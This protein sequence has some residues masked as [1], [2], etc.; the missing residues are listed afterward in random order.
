MKL[1]EIERLKNLIKFELSIVKDGINNICGVDEAG[2]GPLAGPVVA[3]SVVFAKDRL[4]KAEKFIGLN[5]SKKVSEKNRERLYKIII[6]ESEDF[7]LGIVSEK[8]IDEINIHNAVL[9]AMELAVRN[10]KTIP[11]YILIDGIFKLKA[12]F[13]QRTII[14]GDSKC[15]SIAAASIIAKVTR[16]RIMKKYDKEFP[17]YGF[18]VHKGYGTKKHISA[19]KK[20]GRCEIHRKCFGKSY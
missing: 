15:F 4:F 11:Q 3:A 9:L 5:D 7:S 14:G 19:I 2:R 13:S 17:E 18:A 1:N 10:L 6:E 16:D 8:I 20:F 12:D